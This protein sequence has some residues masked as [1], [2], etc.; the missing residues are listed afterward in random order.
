MSEPA[1]GFHAK[2]PSRKGRKENKKVGVCESLRLG[3]FA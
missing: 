1:K 2:A 3:V